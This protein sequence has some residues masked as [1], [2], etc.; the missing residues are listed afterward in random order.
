MA[1][2]I[3]EIRRGFWGNEPPAPGQENESGV[4]EGRMLIDASLVHFRMAR[5]TLSISDCRILEMDIEAQQEGDLV[6]EGNVIA[7][8]NFWFTDYHEIE[9]TLE[10]IMPVLLYRRSSPGMW[11]EQI[12]VEWGQEPFGPAEPELQVR[13]GLSEEDFD[14]ACAH[15]WEVDDK[16]SRQNEQFQIGGTDLT[17]LST[18][19]P[20][21]GFFATLSYF[22]IG[23]EEIMPPN[24]TIH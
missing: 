2:H 6:V 21:A 8:V 18:E 15:V 1:Y 10:I 22:A 4:N 19:N 23:A 14:R 5:V 13:V 9:L 12:A 16:T 24:S 7:R 17:P 11:I 3:I 20:L